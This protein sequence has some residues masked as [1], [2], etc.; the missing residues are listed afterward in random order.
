M[1]LPGNAAWIRGGGC[2]Y[3]CNAGYYFSEW[4]M[5][6]CKT[7]SVEPCAAGFRGRACT[8]YADKVC[9]TECSNASKPVFY[10]KWVVGTAGVGAE[11]EGECPWM[12]EDGYMA[13]M[14][15]YV[16]FQIHECVPEGDA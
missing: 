3:Q 11:L 12:C 2:V 15:D 4:D 14:T 1:G 9:D 8:E 13:T 10:S 6:T 7:C 16:L 5:G